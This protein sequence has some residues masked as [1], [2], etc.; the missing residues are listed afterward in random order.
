[1]DEEMEQALE[2]ICHNYYYYYGLRSFGDIWFL[3]EREYFDHHAPD[4][5]VRVKARTSVEAY[6]KR[7]EEEE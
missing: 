1:M 6:C 2:T 4:S 5:S 3:I 7:F